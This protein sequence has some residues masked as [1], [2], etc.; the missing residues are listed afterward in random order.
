M[1]QKRYRAEK[2]SISTAL[3][4]HC[5]PGHPADKLKFEIF[6][7]IVAKPLQV[8]ANDGIIFLYAVACRSP[9]ST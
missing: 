9:K 5:L 8:C 3:Y 7:G 4:T 1:A 6:F 2:G